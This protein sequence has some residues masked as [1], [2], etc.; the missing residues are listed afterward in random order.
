MVT[1]HESSRGDLTLAWLGEEKGR[2]RDART[3]DF[4]VETLPPCALLMQA[5]QAMH[6]FC[7]NA[8]EV[9]L[10]KSPVTACSQ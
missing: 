2:I 8:A 6:L 4:R 1:S 3:S 10:L 7:T 9:L 5:V